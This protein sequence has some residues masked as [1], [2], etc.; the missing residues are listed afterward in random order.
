MK[1][2]ALQ[3]EIDKAFRKQAGV[4]RKTFL[5][6]TNILSKSRCNKRGTRWT[7]EQSCD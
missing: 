3:E 6:M 2:E 7:K 4:K 1:Y 5:R